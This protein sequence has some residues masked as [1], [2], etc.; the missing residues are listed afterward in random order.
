[1][2]TI[3]KDARELMAAVQAVLTPDLLSK[4]RD[5]DPSN[6]TMGHCY[7]AAEALYHLILEYAPDCKPRPQVARDVDG[8]THWWLLVFDAD[9]KGWIIDPTEDQYRSQGEKPPYLFGRG[10]GF[11]TKE[12]SKRARKVIHRAHSALTPVGR[13]LSSY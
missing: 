3:G 12:P 6:P 11:L 1:M 7:V 13:T 4:G 9:N 8:D 5:Y 2:K 10:R